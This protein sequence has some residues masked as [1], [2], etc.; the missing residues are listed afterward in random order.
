MRDCG[1]SIADIA[2]GWLRCQSRVRDAWGRGTWMGVEWLGGVWSLF[3][4]FVLALLILCL[5]VQVATRY[6][7]ATLVLASLC[8]LAAAANALG[9]DPPSDFLM[10]F[11]GTFFF[12]ATGIGLLALIVRLVRGK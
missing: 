1:T 11:L 4:L 7:L 9:F 6:V 2:D 3:G 10:T 12:F 5:I 8:S